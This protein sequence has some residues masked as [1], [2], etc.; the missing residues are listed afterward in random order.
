MG[1]TYF[2]SVLSSRVIDSC[3]IHDSLV[4]ALSVIPQEGHDGHNCLRR[5][6]KCQFILVDG[7]L[8]DVF[9]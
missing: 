1:L 9:W 2:E 3:D 7:E 6:V 4:L 5:D 8:L